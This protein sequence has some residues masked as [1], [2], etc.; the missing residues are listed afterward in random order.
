MAQVAQ[1]LPNKH[2]ALRS[3]LNTTKKIFLM[4]FYLKTYHI[5]SQMVK[6]LKPNSQ[7]LTL[8]N[9]YLEFWCYFNYYEWKLLKII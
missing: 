9:H 7:N 2:Q 5:I 1:H 6:I 4:K 8:L 3:N